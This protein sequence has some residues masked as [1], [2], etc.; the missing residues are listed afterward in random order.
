MRKTLIAVTTGLALALGAANADALTIGDVRY[1]G[2]IDDG[3]PADATS[4]AS[5]INSLLDLAAGA[6]AAPCTLAASE[7]CDRIN[8]TLSTVGKADAVAAGAVKEDPTDGT[9]SVTGFQWLLAK[10]GGESLVW[11]VGDLSGNQSVPTAGLS[12]LSLYNPGT[13]QVPDGGATLGLLGLG[14]LGLGY[15]RRRRQ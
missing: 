14:L 5:Y 15:V 8:S 12:H 7:D 1:L 13:T 11:Y 4:E 3:A 2:Q 9:V 6:A 10:Y